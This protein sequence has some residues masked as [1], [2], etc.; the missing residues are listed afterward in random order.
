MMKFRELVELSEGL[1]STSKRNEMIGLVVDFLKNL[2][3][4]EIEPAVCMLLGR[5]FPK[6][7]GKKLDISWKTL[8]KPILRISGAKSEDLE[9]AFE[10][11]GDLGKT[12]AAVFRLEA[13]KPQ[14][15]LVERPL[16][17]REVQESLKKV[18]MIKGPGSIKRKKRVL[19]GLLNRSGPLEAKYLV[20]IVVGEMRT[21]FKEGLMERAA[22]E[23]FEIPKGLVHRATMF[24]GDVA[25]T[26]RIAVEGGKEAI[27]T[28]EPRPFRPIKPMLAQVA[29][30]VDEAI[31]THDGRTALEHKLDGA[32]IQVHKRGEEVK[33]FSRRLSDVTESLPEIVR[34]VSSEMQVDEAIVEG[35]VIAV[36]EDGSPL[37]FQSLLRRFRR[38][39]KIEQMKR[40]V[41]VKLQLFDL[42]CLNGRSLVDTSYEK[43]R[44]ELGRVSG[45]IELSEQVKVSDPAEGKKFLD[46]ALE[47]GHEGLMAKEFGSPYTPGTRGK[48]WLKVKPVLEPLDLVIVGAEFGFGRRHEWLSD[49]YLAA[50]ER[51]TGDFEIVGKTFK[52]LTDEEIQTMTQKLE[53]LATE[54]EQRRVWVRPEVVVEVAYNDIQESPKYPCGMALR[55]ARINRIRDDKSPS[56]ADAIERVRKIYEKQ[57]KRR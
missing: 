28:L 35:E 16:E 6:A 51:G 21:G 23:A 36:D 10:R 54:R 4:E 11:T 33:I 9:A 25:R 56:E 45:S 48:R 31:E 49:Y 13:T 41:P 40:E 57:A 38:E 44:E 24:A 29:E 55:F 3:N 27:K 19:E 37:P 2:E 20:K 5:P 14:Q 8:R 17:L 32:R 43:R 42:I 50:R 47:V 26:A 18:A 52:G 7:S 39:R 1:R 15:T 22:A 30:D 53:G 12:T 34:L 46:Q